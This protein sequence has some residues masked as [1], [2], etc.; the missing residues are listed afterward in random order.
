MSV[1]NS[2]LA[3]VKMAPRRYTRE[4]LDGIV[5]DSVAKMESSLQSCTLT[6]EYL[7]RGEDEFVKGSDALNFVWKIEAAGYCDT[8]ETTVRC[9]HAVERGV[10]FTDRWKTALNCL[11]LSDT[12]RQS[13]ENVT[14]LGASDV[15]CELLG[16]AKEVMD[17]SLGKT[18]ALNDGGSRVVYLLCGQIE[19]DGSLL[20]AMIE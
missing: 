12:V 3:Q 5:H 11:T 15:K 1:L 19:N 7:H 10:P 16:Q 14:E 9:Y 8:Y 2:S 18:I 4:R 6:C 13:A 20:A 17:D